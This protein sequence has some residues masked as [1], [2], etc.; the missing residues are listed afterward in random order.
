MAL[1]LLAFTGNAQHEHHMQPAPV[2]KT[3]P[4]KKAKTPIRKAAPVVK[5]KSPVA[6]TMEHNM[7][8]HHM[9]HEATDTPAEMDHH[10][11][12]HDTTAHQHH[13]MPEMNSDT[14][15]HRHHDMSAIASDTMMHQHHGMSTMSHAY[16][17]NLPMNRNGSGTGWLPDASPM[18]G[19]MVHAGKWMF[20]LHGNLFLRYNNQD[21]SNKGSRGDAMVD[22]PNWIMAMGQ[23]RV[24]ARGLFHFNVM[25][26][27]DAL[28]TGG[29]G[30]PLLFQTGETWEGKPLID[31][32]HPHD[33]FSE[34]SVSY[35]HAF[36]NKVDVFAYLGYPGEPALGSVA[37]MHRP[38]AL[39]NPD[40]PLSHHWVD[41]THIT[42]GVAT[43]GVRYGKL[44]LEGSGF[45]GREPDENRFD[46]DKPRFDSR[47]ARL[48]FN[49]NSNWALQVSH[50]FIKS[51]EEL[52]GDEDVNR[53]TAS[54]VY[55]NKYGK[56]T[57]LNATALWGM[58]KTP[59]H[60]AEHAALAEA[61][62]YSNRLALYTR[63]E[64]VQKSAEE[65]ALDEP[66]FDHHD[67]F[68]VH[69][70]TLGSSYDI[71][72]Y[73]PVRVAAGAQVSFYNADERLSALYGKRPMAFEVYLRLYPELMQ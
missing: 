9:N 70:L 59:G 3:Q 51:P 39:T 23:R 52:H 55:S 43:V 25:L 30:Y 8:H 1:L 53:T 62:L 2:K 40:A 73:S 42:F 46:L 45:T 67:I 15:A 31:R 33:L 37:F 66:E 38:S 65:L 11:G 54:A 6:D 20:M 50:G 26:S 56:N 47:S 5:K 41:A 49:P 69:A 29:A 4:I 34:L 71:L 12:H 44:K 19:Y 48:S 14:I 68:P 57:L 18:Y 58:N 17:L 21:F 32:Q 10:I 61:S 24:G 72:R 64:W 63:Y 27:A 60:D 13:D 16:S 7:D 36:S 22:A 35:A 28:I